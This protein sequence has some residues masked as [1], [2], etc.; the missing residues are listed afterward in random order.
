MTR[1]ATYYLK[2]KGK[3]KFGID[4]FGSLSD[5]KTW[6]SRLELKGLK[7]MQIYWQDGYPGLDGWK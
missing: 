4:R 3:T 6:K 5:Y 7:L 1:T 2:D